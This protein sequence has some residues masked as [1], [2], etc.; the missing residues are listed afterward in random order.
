[1][2]QVIELAEKAKDNNE[3]FPLIRGGPDGRQRQWHKELL[4]RQESGEGW[5]SY[6]EFCSDK[7]KGNTEKGNYDKEDYSRV[8]PPASYSCTLAD[9]SM[10]ME[11]A[12]TE[13]EESMYNKKNDSMDR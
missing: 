2:S 5:I 1:M 10:V 4:A 11:G 12:D 13:A 3:L 8:P 7:S 6:A 9:F